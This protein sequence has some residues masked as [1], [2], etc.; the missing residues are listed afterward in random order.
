MA[1]G[2]LDRRL[3]GLD[4]DDALFFLDLVSFADQD[5]QDVRRLDAVSENRKFD[6][7]GHGALIH[8]L[9]NS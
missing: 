4:F 3:V 5:F 9:D 1:A 8:F 7:N 6:L 2:H